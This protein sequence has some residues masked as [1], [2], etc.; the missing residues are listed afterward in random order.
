MIQPSRS[1]QERRPRRGGAFTGCG[2]SWIRITVTT[3]VPVLWIQPWSPRR[4]SQSLQDPTRPM[5][6]LRDPSNGT[7]ANA[8]ASLVTCHHLHRSPAQSSEV[9]H[10]SRQPVYGQ[11]PSAQGTQAGS[12][13]NLEKPFLQSIYAALNT[14]QRNQ[15][16]GHAPALQA[17]RRLQKATGKSHVITVGSTY[18]AILSPGMYTLSPCPAALAQSSRKP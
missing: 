18:V 4:K 15:A 9:L 17:L 2:S 1:S 7:G 16:C 10:Q 3:W 11:A 12:K 5:R 8:L 14:C 6:G 13:A